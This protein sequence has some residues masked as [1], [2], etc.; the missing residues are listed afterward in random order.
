MHTAKASG[1]RRIRASSSRRASSG[2]AADLEKL[3]ANV[4]QFKA[5]FRL[6]GRAIPV[7]LSNRDS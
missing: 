6:H 1:Y 2:T 5:M 7:R 3:R 4:A